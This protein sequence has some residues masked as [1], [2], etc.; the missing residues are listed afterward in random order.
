MRWRVALRYRDCVLKSRRRAVVIGLAVGVFISALVAIVLVATH[1]STPIP[2]LQA[3]GTSDQGSGAS[4]PAKTF[5]KFDGTK[6]SLADYRGTPIVLNFF[7]S[8]CAPCVGELPAMQSVSQKLTG[9]VTFVG[10]DNH[11]TLADGKDIAS[12][13]GVTYTLGSDPDSSFFNQFG[14]VYMPTTVFISADGR[15]VDKH[16]GAYSADA[17]EKHLHDLFGI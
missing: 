11:D 10:L 12:K 3:A 14:A 2:T 8:W 16:A 15:V 5:T 17:L 9:K 13:S 7:A 1:K 4:V 6:A